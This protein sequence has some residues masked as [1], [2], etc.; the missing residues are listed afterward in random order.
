MAHYNLN[1]YDEAIAQ[2]E[3]GYRAVPQAVFLYNIAQAHRAAERPQRAL[4]FYRKYLRQ[5]P[6][7]KNIRE[8]QDLIT[9]LEKVGAEAGKPPVETVAPA[10]EPAPVT[11]TP[12]PPPAPLVPV[13]APV[14]VRAPAPRRKAWPIALGVVGGVIVAGAA[15]GL[16]V[17]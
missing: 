5:D 4:E 3:A 7:A 12:E 8:V 13:P 16:G 14:V 15:V 6:G 17:Y 1:E 11:P 9:G 10:P 2:F